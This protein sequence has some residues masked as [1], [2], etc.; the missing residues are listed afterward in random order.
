MNFK[1][2]SFLL[3]LFVFQTAFSQ[4]KNN[5]KL[6]SP[7]ETVKTFLYYTSEET[8]DAKLASKTLFPV[9]T[10]V[11]KEDLAIYLKKILDGKGLY[12]ELNQISTEANYIDS[13]S[14]QA[15]YVLFKTFPQIYLEKIGRN[16]YFSKETVN[17]L[18]E[19][20][21]HLYPYGT[22]KLINA[23]PNVSH[24]KVLGLEIWQHLAFFIILLIAF[25]I[26]KVSVFFLDKGIRKIVNNIG[27]ENIG[28]SYIHRVSIPLSLILALFILRNLFPL[29]QFSAFI[30]KYINLTLDIF[31]P[32]TFAYALYKIVDILTEY[33]ALAAAKTEGTLDDQLVPLVR[34]TL[35]LFVIV[36][37]L[38]FILQSLNINITAFLAGLSI[39]GLAFA[40]AAQD[41]LKNFFGSVMIFIDKPFQVGDWINFDGNGGTVEEVGFR[42]TRIRTVNNSLI[43]IPNGKLADLTVD[44]LGMRKFRRFSTTLTITYDTPPDLIEVFVEG[45]RDIANKHPLVNQENYLIYLNDLGAS[46]LNISFI[47]YLFVN[48]INDEQK[49]RHEIISEIIRLAAHLNVR[50]AFPTQTLHMET[51]PDKSSLSPVYNARY[52]EYQKLKN[53]FFNKKGIES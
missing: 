14:N 48:N 7:H 35:K 27:S 28:E 21:E 2:L 8:F 36:S 34:K 3:L 53:E 38:L 31:I 45:L 15:Y 41:T 43:Y 49:T 25:V 44:N 11:P 18:P 29:L 46:S 51:F 40:L 22:S 10:T 42:S 9:N 32:F 33:L 5:V 26:Q 37:G 24:K 4:N 12:I 19:I 1:K 50:F 20:Y 30:N 47:V 39:G 52:N 6:S 23:L 17:A 13:S 16:W